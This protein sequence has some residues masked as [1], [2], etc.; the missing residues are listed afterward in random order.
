MSCTIA[1]GISEFDGSCISGFLFIAKLD[2]NYTHRF[3]ELTVIDKV[4][5]VSVTD[6][7]QSLEQIKKLRHPYSK[8]LAQVRVLMLL[9][10]L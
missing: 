9:C 5:E 6:A 1:C 8:A 3:K 2:N 7:L 4:S 10:F